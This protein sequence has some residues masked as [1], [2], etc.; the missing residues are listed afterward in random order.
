MNNLEGKGVI[1]YNY[2]EDI[3]Y[4]YIERFITKGEHKYDYSFDLEGFIIDLDEDGHGIA[5]VLLDASEKLNVPKMVLKFI[6]GGNFKAKVEKN[7][8]L[9]SFSLISVIR[10]KLQQFTLNA[11]RLNTPQLKETGVECQ[12]APMVQQV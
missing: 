1:D 11:E 4:F 3:L 6:K 7:L 12:I 10:N 2:N 8:I 9:V 5:I